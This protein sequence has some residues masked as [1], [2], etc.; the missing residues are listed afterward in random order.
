M[1]GNLLKDIVGGIEGAVIMAT[2]FITPFLNSRRARWGATDEEVN[3]TLPGDDLVPN[4][5]GGYT[6]AITIRASTARVW[7]WLVQLGQ[8]RGGFYSYDLLENMVGC[9]IHSADRIIPELQNLEVGNRIL[10][11]PS[12]QGYT[13]DS[14][15]PRRMIVLLERVDTQSGK[16][17]KLTKKMPD[18]YINQ[19]WVLFLEKI[20]RSNT[21][22]ISRSRND[23]SQSLV[24]T[25]VYGI[26][27][28]ISLVMDRKMLRGIKKRAE[29][30]V[31][32]TK[33]AA[34]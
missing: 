6:H 34:V 14:I 5:K 3:K 9:N 26:F 10:I 12:G 15:A 25:L 1:A 2:A 13:V 22:L 27:G 30:G 24:N 32:R 20:D 11:Y 17:F 18:K 31:K 23:W 16:T 33:A 29:A 28:P 19:S 4:L 21:R 8:G 7:P